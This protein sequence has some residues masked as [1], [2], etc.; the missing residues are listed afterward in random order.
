[1]PYYPDDDNGEVRHTYPIYTTVPHMV[2]DYAGLSIPAVYA[3]DLI[4]Y[5]ILRRDAYISLL[6]RT[7][8]GQEYLEN[9]WCR[10]QTE[11]DREAL[12]KLIAGGAARGI[13]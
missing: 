12:R 6:S 7:K 5:L 1:M 3:L 13:K 2:A 4:D 10:E 8:S 11:P 9:A